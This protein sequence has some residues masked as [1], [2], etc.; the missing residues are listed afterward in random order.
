MALPAMFSMLINALYN[1]V[2]SIYVARY[3]SDALAAVSL[4]FPVQSLLIAVAAGTGVGINSLIA[5]RLGEGRKELA[6]R[7]AT[8][9]AVP[10]G[11]GVGGLRPA[12]YLRHRAVFVPV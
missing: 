1:V 10:G 4:A 12:G 7:A 3:S 5:R 11:A 2:D 6:N 9:R 8:P